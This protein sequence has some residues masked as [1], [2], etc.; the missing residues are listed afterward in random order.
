MNVHFKPNEPQTLALQ[1]PRAEQFGEYQITY[2]L[3]DGRLLKVSKELA[4]QINMLDL[5][6]G[7]MFIICKQMQRHEQ[8]KRDTPVWCVWLSSETDKAHTAQSGRPT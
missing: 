5:Q 7:D 8:R 6:Q 2:T 1:E 4:S 3:T